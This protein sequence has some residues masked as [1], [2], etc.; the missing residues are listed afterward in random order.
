MNYIK[1]ILS[2]S[3]LFLF[4]G[5]GQMRVKESLLPSVSGS[6]GEVLIIMETNLWDSKC[7]TDMKDLLLQDV[8][9][10]PQNE[11]MFNPV[12]INHKAFSELFRIHRNII[13]TTISNSVKENR[14]T[15]EN[16][17]WAKPQTII[18]M[19]AKS[20]NDFIQ[21]F[22]DNKSKIL[23]LLLK[24]ERDRLMNNYKQYP[25]QG[26]VDRIK[27]KSGIDLIVPK[28]YTYDT[29]TNNFIWI[30]HETPQTSQGVFIYWYE[31]TDT[32]MFSKPMLINKRNDIL[33]KYVAG[34]RE[35]SYMT[36]EMQVPP[37]I[38]K[39]NFHNKYF[40]ELRGLW[41]VEG[42]YMGGAF[43]SISTIDNK[44]NR[45]VTV[46]GYVY[47]PKYDKRNYMRQVE[48]ILYSVSCPK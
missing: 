1:N 10:L 11:P 3:V 5:C 34:P 6:P 21:L 45:I 42:D 31:Y 37:T 43:V 36:T 24:A 44:N 40:A 15:V 39:Y 47:A 29:D 13:Y 27:H 32:A 20:K 9:G 8:E 46:D 2:I 48:A 30:S 23:N 25:E 33:Q 16:D 19:Y 7:G 22:N 14:I 28:G 18:N 12:H 41:K 4:V 38:N 35:G 17:K 26:V